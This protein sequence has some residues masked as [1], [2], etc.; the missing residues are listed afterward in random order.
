MHGMTSAPTGP[1]K[2]LRSLAPELFQTETSAARHSRRE[3]RRVPDT[4][5]A[6]ALLDVARHADVALLE[7]DQIA[8]THSLPRSSLGVLLGNLFSETRERVADRLMEGERSYRATLLGMRHGVDVVHMVELTARE[9]GN[10]LLASWAETW[11]RRREPLV[12][13]VERQLAW[14]ATHTDRALARATAQ[15][16]ARS[17]SPAPEQR[18]AVA[19]QPAIPPQ[20]GH[21]GRR[22]GWDAVDESSRESFPASD[23]PAGWAGKDVAPPT[24]NGDS[25][26]DSAGRNRPF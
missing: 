21:A 1:E 23:A 11:L 5:P 15:R 2:L 6:A 7:L 8:R 10:G 18:T 24:L 19:V 17:N 25:D 9:A 22:E 3:A 4:P 16:S 26:R 12:Q 14:Y 13:E 20:P